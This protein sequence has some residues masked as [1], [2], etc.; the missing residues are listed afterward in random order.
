MQFVTINI[1][2]PV[3]ISQAVVNAIGLLVPSAASQA[4]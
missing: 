3:P 4:K 2:V 1:S